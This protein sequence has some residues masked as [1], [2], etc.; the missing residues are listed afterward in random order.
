MA[1]S[2]EKERRYWYNARGLSPA[3]KTVAPVKN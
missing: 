1:M 2:I 3:G